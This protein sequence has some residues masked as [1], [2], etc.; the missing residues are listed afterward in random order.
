M[1]RLKLNINKLRKGVNI[2][3][4]QFLPRNRQNLLSHPKNVQKKLLRIAIVMKMIYKKKLSR[5]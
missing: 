1:N 2:R 4:T 3:S 5:R